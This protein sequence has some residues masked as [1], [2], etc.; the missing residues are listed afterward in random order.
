MDNIQKNLEKCVQKVGM[1]RYN[2]FHDSRGE[3]C[4]AIALLDFEDNGVVKEIPDRSKVVMVQTPQCFH[5]SVIAE[6]HRLGAE[7]LFYQH[8]SPDT[9]IQQKPS[10][11]MVSVR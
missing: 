1:V 10:Y 11:C 5:Y 4:F 9:D 7:E 2:A 8:C 6:A 3:L